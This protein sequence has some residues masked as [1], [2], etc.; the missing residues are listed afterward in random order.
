MWVRRDGA[1]VRQR[2]IFRRNVARTHTGT[3]RSGSTGADGLDGLDV[4][5]GGAHARVGARTMARVIIFVKGCRIVVLG[6][7]SWSFMGGGCRMAP[8]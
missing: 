2:W 3:S 4:V 5:D 1:L 6:Y 8:A 7:T